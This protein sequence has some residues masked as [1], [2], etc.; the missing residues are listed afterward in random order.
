MPSTPRL[1]VIVGT[2]GS[3]KD[4]LIRAVNDLGTLHAGIVPKHTSRARRGD[5]G[6]EMI[7]PGHSNHDLDGCDIRYENYG[8][9]YGIKSAR[10]WEGLMK[11]DFQVAVVSNLYAIK[12]LQRIF[13][14][15]MV[16]VYVHS[17]M[18][19]GEYQCEAAKYG[20][21]AGYVERRVAEY[22]HAFGIY[23]R[24]F[25]AFN[26]VLIYSG[27]PEDL[28]DQIFRLFRAYERGDLPYT[29][30]RPVASG[31]IW[32]FKDEWDGDELPELM[33]GRGES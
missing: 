24:H 21:D 12:D 14:E 28:Y 25:L 4:L 32:D 6:E 33:G 3:G 15:L 11:G 7:C 26:H 13:G 19:A 20:G 8:D 1:F 2:P 18:D 22:Q 30:A 16:L 31:R 10:I 23:L 9:K 27:L 29:T 17:E 5:D